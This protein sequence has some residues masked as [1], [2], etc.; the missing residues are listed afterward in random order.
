[1]K[2]KTLQAFEKDSIWLKIA[3]YDERGKA[4]DLVENGIREA[5]FEV[6]ALGIDVIGEM[7][8]NVVCFKVGSDIT[9][10]GSYPYFVE[11]IGDRIKFTVAYGMLQ[12][13]SK[14]I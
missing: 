13:M 7:K 2:A 11:L 6:P 12:V 4:F 3:V 1:M 5:K 9:E 8:E 10:Q 14:E